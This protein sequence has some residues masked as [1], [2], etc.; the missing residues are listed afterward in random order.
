[1]D[2]KQIDTE[3]LVTSPEWEQFQEA[4]R[5]A[6]EP[7]IEINVDPAS[8]KRFHAAMDRAAPGSDQTFMMEYRHEAKLH[9]DWTGYA[10]D[11]CRNRIINQSQ[12]GMFYQLIVG[13]C[14]PSRQQFTGR[15]AYWD[16]PPPETKDTGQ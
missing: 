16:T 8:V 6:A 10:P 9:G 7:T 4:Y 15:V 12:M 2:E 3:T 11:P 1:M 14:T 5:R 13:T